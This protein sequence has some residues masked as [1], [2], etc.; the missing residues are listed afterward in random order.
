MPLLQ[1]A[2]DVSASELLLANLPLE[3]G[4][5]AFPVMRCSV[6]GVRRRAMSA[7][8]L[9]HRLTRDPPSGQHASSTKAAEL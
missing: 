7:G 2:K 8:T 1:K 5:C 6:L 3:N 4:C 9:S